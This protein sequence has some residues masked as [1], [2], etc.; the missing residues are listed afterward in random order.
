MRHTALAMAI[1][2]SL[3]LGVA[4]TTGSAFVHQDSFKEQLIGTWKAVEVNNVL[5]DG[6]KVQSYGPN[7][8]GMLMLDDRGHFSLILIRTDLPKFASG[9]RDLGS[10]EENKAVIQGSLSNYG[11]YSVSDA[12][13]TLVLR[14]EQS[15]FPNWS[16][17]EQ[18]RFIA[19]I[20]RDEL[21]W[22]NYVASNGGTAQ[23]VWKRTK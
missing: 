13:R 4:L 3:C 8:S 21:K 19:T 6:I 1:A 9:K 18:R 20:S 17:T 15:S 23:I 14:I 10:H 11:T 7:P 2:A 5:E 22:V 16:G 12:D